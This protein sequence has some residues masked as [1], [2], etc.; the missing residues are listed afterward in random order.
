MKKNTI[1]SRRMDR[2]LA[3]AKPPSTPTQDWPEVPMGT[4]YTVNQS[5]LLFGRDHHLPTY[6]RPVMTLVNRDGWWFVLPGIHEQPFDASDFFH[7]PS[8]S[9]DCLIRD[10]HRPDQFFYVGY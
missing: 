1:V 6:R 3:T 8:D 9:P 5:S 4:V 2:P 7:I 10:E